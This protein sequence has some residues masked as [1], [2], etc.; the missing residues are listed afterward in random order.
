MEPIASNAEVGPPRRGGDGAALAQAITVGKD[1]EAVWRDGHRT[2]FPVI[3]LRDN[4]VCSQCGDPS[5]GKRRLRVSSISADLAPATLRVTADGHLEIKWAPDGHVSIYDALWLRNESA[6]ES[7]RRSNIMCWGSSLSRKLPESD[8]DEVI[9]DPKA[10]LTFYR[11]LRDFGLT[12]VR[13]VRPQV[14]EIEVFSQVVGPLVETN[15][16]R[17]FDI[18]FTPDQLSIANST[19]ALMP[20]TDEPYRYSPPGIMMFHC[21]DAS[22]DGGGVS[23]FV[24]G[25][26]VAETLRDTEPKM[27]DLLTRI[28]VPYRRHYKGKVDVQAAAPLIVVDEQGHIEG[29]RFND[30]V[31]APL[32]PTRGDVSA[33]YEAFRVLSELYYDERRWCRVHLRPGDLVVFDNHRVLHGRTA[34]SADLKRRFLRLCHVD[35]TEFHSRF[36][37]LGRSLG[38]ADAELHFPAGSQA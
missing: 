33:F 28:K 23:T 6:S 20:H 16:G 22:T 10:R 14:G 8:A 29:V 5:I 31:M 17:V 15:F 34:F 9:A 24:D 30:R 37:I 11:Q 13:N 32:N 4:C 27:F 12:V 7:A 26:G 18:V 25:F 2:A 19:E 36:R 1:V 35:R 38:A 21:I 3:W